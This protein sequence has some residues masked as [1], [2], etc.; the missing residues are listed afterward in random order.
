IK[1]NAL[2]NIIF[3][4]T[5]RD[6]ISIKLNY[7][8]WH[9]FFEKDESF[10]EVIFM[11]AISSIINRF[12]QKSYYLS[13]VGNELFKDVNNVIANDINGCLN[14]SDVQKELFVNFLKLNKD[15]DQGPFYTLASDLEHELLGGEFQVKIDEIKEEILFV[16]DECEMEFELKL[17]SS[18]IRELTPRIIYLKYFLQIGD[19][20][21][22]EEPEKHINPKN[23][24]I[25]VKYL[26]KAINE[27]LNIIITTHSDYIL[28][29]FNN[30]MRLGNANDEIFEKLGYEKNNIL[31]YENVSIYNF[32]KESKYSY[33]AEKIEINETGFD[34]NN[35]YEVNNELYDESVD[36][37]DAQ[38]N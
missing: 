23:Q 17:T 31:D 2:S 21:I 14:L 33:I 10:A 37:I 35:F 12:N 11:M 22:I 15:I 7:I 20:L 1:D 4:T 16:D 19:T 18:S 3:L 38:K 13:A 8:L 5:N 30:F 34:E 29:K 25:L 24:L 6:Y 9:N 36:I 27:G 32:K 26:V 28:E